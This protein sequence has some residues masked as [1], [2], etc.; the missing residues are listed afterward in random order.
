MGLDISDRTTRIWSDRA[1]LRIGNRAAGIGHGP[2]SG[3]LKQV[4]ALTEQACTDRIDTAK[5][6]RP[7]T[8]LHKIAMRFDHG[9]QGIRV[10]KLLQ[11]DRGLT[12]HSRIDPAGFVVHVL[13]TA[14]I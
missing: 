3:D 14:S 10:L 8:K 9:G 4:T 1:S 6:F 2:Q 5:S 12:S 7:N 11:A 13:A